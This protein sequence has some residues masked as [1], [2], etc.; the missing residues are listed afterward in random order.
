MDHKTCESLINDYIDDKLEPKTIDHF[1]KHIESCPQCYEELSVNYSLIN[2]IRQIDAGMDMSDDFDTS[3]EEKIFLYKQKK[4]NLR[5]IS[6]VSGVLLFIT[7]LVITI[8]VSVFMNTE[9]IGYNSNSSANKILIKT[10]A[11]PVDLDPVESQIAKYNVDVIKYFH[12]INDQPME[13]G[14]K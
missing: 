5:S 2:A 7:S 10:D 14:R 13:K 9:K 4:K 8:V 6:I 11:I 12:S 3:L 1:L